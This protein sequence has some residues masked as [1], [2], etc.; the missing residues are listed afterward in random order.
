MYLGYAAEAFPGIQ[1]AI[2]MNDADLAQAQVELAATQVEAA[3]SFLSVADG[4]TT[5]KM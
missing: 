2:E 4:V 3:A 5:V 1:Q